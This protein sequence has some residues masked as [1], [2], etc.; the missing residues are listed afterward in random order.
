MWL[1]KRKKMAIIK[2]T[3]GGD[4]FEK[5]LKDR[6]TCEWNGKKRY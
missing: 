2:N 3:M 4:L 1:S 6:S 5:A